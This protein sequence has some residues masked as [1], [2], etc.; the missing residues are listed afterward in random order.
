MY[1]GWRIQRWDTPVSDNGANRMVSLVDDGELAITLEDAHSPQRLRWRFVFQKYPAYRNILEEH[2]LE[3]WQHL[4]E[5]KQRCGNTFSV[6]DSPWIASFRPREPLLDVYY[7]ALVH[8]VITTGDD[9]VEVLSPQPPQIENLG[10]APADA[11][12]PG[13]STTL[14]YPQDKGQI[15]QLVKDIRSRNS[16]SGT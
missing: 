11:P 3:L 4:D 8:Y 10:P 5:T 15:E 1:E 16:T 12:P 9:V 2:R 7:P 13:K 6:L 14:Y